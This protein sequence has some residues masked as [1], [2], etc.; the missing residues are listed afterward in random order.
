MSPFCC[1][2]VVIPKMIVALINELVDVLG[3][4]AHDLVH[5]DGIYQSF[6]VVLLT[7]IHSIQ[8]VGKAALHLNGFFILL[9]HG[10]WGT[11]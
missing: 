7:N 3:G 8:Y 2:L 11:F 10:P 1:C 6:E 5:G 4:V 9:S